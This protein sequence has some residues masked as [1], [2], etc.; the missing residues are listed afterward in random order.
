MVRGISFSCKILTIFFGTFT[1]LFGFPRQCFFPVEIIQNIR[2]P[3]FLVNPAYDF[4][5][6]SFPVENTFMLC[7]EQ[8]FLVPPVMFLDVI[9]IQ[10]VLVP[11]RADPTRSWQRCRLNIQACSPSQLEILQGKYFVDKLSRKSI[12]LLFVGLIN[13][14]IRFKDKSL[15]PSKNWLTPTQ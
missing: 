5:Q 3:V 6:V 2:T 15:L 11:A 9:Q 13:E 1:M 14:F 12:K 4:W 8:W 7:N 10:N